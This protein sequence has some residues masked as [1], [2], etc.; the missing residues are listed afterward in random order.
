MCVWCVMCGWC[1]MS[2]AKWFSLFSRAHEA[3]SQGRKYTRCVVGWEPYPEIGTSEYLSKL[4]LCMAVCL[5]KRRVPAYVPLSARVS[6]ELGGFTH[7]PRLALSFFLSPPPLSLSLCLSVSRPLSL[8]HTHTHTHSHTHTHT[9]GLGAWVRPVTR[10]GVLAMGRCP[11]L[12]AG[13]SW[14]LTPWT[15]G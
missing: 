11:M 2:W 7:S 3:R 6:F 8:S 4:K 12:P 1:A 13:T 10:A 9:R 14:T 5:R 15:P